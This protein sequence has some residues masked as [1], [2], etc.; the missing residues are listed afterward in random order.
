VA[1]TASTPSGSGYE[2]I[3]IIQLCDASFNPQAAKPK[4][5]QRPILPSWSARRARMSCC[6]SS[7]TTLTCGTRSARRR[8]SDTRSRLG[9]PC[10]NSAATLATIYQSV[11]I[12]TANG[13]GPFELRDAHRQIDEYVAAGVTH[14]IFFDPA[15]TVNGYAASR[16]R[17]SRSTRSGNYYRMLRISTGAPVRLHRRCQSSAGSIINTSG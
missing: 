12:S 8:S 5:L 14:I 6:V 17:S 15:R 2:G 3:A 7:R 13:A 10:R 1:Y 16:K 11:L 4:L 9:S